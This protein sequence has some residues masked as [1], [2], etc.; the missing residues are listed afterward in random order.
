MGNH[1]FFKIFIDTRRANA[2]WRQDVTQR[3]QFIR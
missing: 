3:S 2:V 1:Y